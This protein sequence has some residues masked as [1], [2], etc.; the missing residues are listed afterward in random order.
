MVKADENFFPKDLKL[1]FKPFLRHFER[2]YQCIKL[3]EKIGENEMWLDCACG[4]GYGT[5]ILSN[6]TKGIIG[7]DIS[8]DAVEYANENYSTN[9]CKFTYD[10]NSIGNN[11]DVIFSIE[12]IE[13]MSKDNGVKF[14]NKLNSNLKDDGLFIITTPI[15]ETTNNNPINIYHCLEYSDNDFQSLL[16]ESGFSIMESLFVETTFTDGEIKKQGYYKCRK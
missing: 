1:E 16:G 13:H 11:F 2:Y 5:N 8:K 3:L 9:N 10:L 12:T 7:Y 15:V 14:L 4:S 6:F